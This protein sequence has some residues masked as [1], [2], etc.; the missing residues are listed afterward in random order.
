VTPSFIGLQVPKAT[1]LQ[2]RQYVY[3][4]GG[5]F[6]AASA[7]VYDASARALANAAKCVVISVSYRSASEHKFP[8]A[9]E[10]AYAVLQGGIKTMPNST[11]S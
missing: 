5:G 3:F 9:A 1:K 11:R 10:D 7:D 2:L 4:H 6:V 8:A